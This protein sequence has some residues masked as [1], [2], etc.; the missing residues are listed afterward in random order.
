MKNRREQKFSKDF[1]KLGHWSRAR[2]MPGTNEY[3]RGKGETA[4]IISHIGPGR[5]QGPGPMSHCSRAFP[6]PGTDEALQYKLPPLL[7]PEHIDAHTEEPLL[8]RCCPNFPRRRRC[9]TP[10][11]PL[12]HTPPPPPARGLPAALVAPAASI[13]AAGRPSARVRNPT[14][15]RAPSPPVAGD[16]PRPAGRRGQKCCG[17]RCGARARCVHVGPSRW[18]LAWA[19]LSFFF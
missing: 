10:P 6:G 11:P 4:A 16:R 5:S 17:A 19:H 1:Q 7:L 15:C 13:P 3:S 8:G 14:P 18:A 9:S 12:L 2:A